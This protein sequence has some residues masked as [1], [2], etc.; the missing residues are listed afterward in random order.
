MIHQINQLKLYQV[1]ND[2]RA[3]GMPEVNK[4]GAHTLTAPVTDRLT[5]SVDGV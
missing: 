2:Y 1:W 4:F 5:E 3:E